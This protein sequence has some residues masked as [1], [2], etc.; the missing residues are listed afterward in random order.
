MVNDPYADFSFTLSGNGYVLAGYSG[1]DTEVTVPAEY[2]GK[3]VTAIGSRAFYDC[4]FITKII[5][6]NS[7]KEIADQAFGYCTS[8][9]TVEIPACTRILNS[10]F[11]GCTSLREVTLPDG[12][13][14]IGS[15]LFSNCN[16]LQK[17]TI[18]SGSVLRNTFAGCANLKE[19]IIGE[20][21]ASVAQGAFED[22]TSLQYLTLP[23]V[24]E[25]TSFNDYYFNLEAQT[26]T[27]NG[28]G[29]ANLEPAE[30][31]SY[32]V[33]GHIFALPANG[34]DWYYSKRSTIIDGVTYQYSG[35][36]IT[37]TSWESMYEATVGVSW[38]RPQTWTAEFYIPQDNSLVKLTVTDQLISIYD[39]VFDGCGCE[40]DIV[41][42]FPVESVSVMGETELYLDEFSLDDYILR[43]KHTD[44]WIEDLPLAEHLS[45][46]DKQELQQSGTHSLTISYGGQSC[47][48]NIVLNLH[49][50]DDAV[51]EDM[52]VV[53]D[54]TVKNL[55]VTGIPEDT[56]VIWENNG[57]TEVGEY[58]VTATLKKTYYEDKTLTAHLYIRQAQYNI[59]Y[60]LGVE[61]AENANPAT[62]TFGEGL[63]LSSPTS[64][65]WEFLGW[66]ADA[67]FTEKVTVISAQEYGDK[68]FYAKW[69]SIFVYSNGTITGL[70]DYGKTNCTVLVIPAEIDEQR[71]TSIGER[72]FA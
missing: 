29:A 48:F 49:T 21:V 24:D 3:A 67:D 13:V 12:V 42:K 58:T 7:L 57:Q 33:G 20:N 51:L 56:E 25:N 38:R 1:T 68:A 44:G 28:T 34:T 55:Q 66:Y 26:Y 60:V 63:T 2:K 36:P 6:P 65:A 17:V 40:I 23:R 46:A 19:I 72:A 43:V 14:T 69:R 70:T 18:L 4:S 16:S 64:G 39:E 59:T 11:L 62:Y 45:E 9:Q 35:K 15:N 61:E 53:A 52:T 27:I 37:V 22:C 71:I 30:T 5:L 31:K 47:K 32:S 10:V 41:Q 8:L 50:F 54:G